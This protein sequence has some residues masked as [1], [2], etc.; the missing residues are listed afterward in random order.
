MKQRLSS[1]KKLKNFFSFGWLLRNDK[2]MMV[3]SLIIA[4]TIWFNVISGPANITD[5]SID[6][7]VSVDLSGSY[8]YQSGLRIVGDSTF[9]VKVNVSGPWATLVKLNESDFRVRADMTAITHDGVNDVPLNVSRNSTVTDYDVLSVTP[10][11]VQIACEYWE[12][13]AFFEVEVDTDGIM[14]EDP[15]TDVV[16]HAVIDTADF[17][18]GTV[19]LDGPEKVIE[20][21]ERLVAVIETTQ[22]MKKQTQ[23][24]VPL[25]AYDKNGREV[26]ISACEIR[27]IP[28]GKV[29]V[30]V[31]LWERR[32]MDVVY[33][34][35]NLP[36]NVTD[37]EAFIEKY[38]AV[39]PKTVEACGTEKALDSAQRHLNL[40]AID[41]DALLAAESMQLEYTVDVP[42]EKGT[43]EPVTVTVKLAVD[44]LQSLTVTVTPDDEHVR[45]VNA[46]GED[47]SDEILDAYMVNVPN[48]QKSLNLSL[49]GAAE[50]IAT[51]TSDDFV[52]TVTLDETTD[53]AV[54]SY[55]ATVTVDGYEDVWIFGE[56]RLGEYRMTVELSQGRAVLQNE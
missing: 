20:S 21:I 8:A 4:A 25:T 41:F 16:G 18:N 52:W 29:R 10:S 35:E 3:V 31:P 19:T 56:S 38:I 17:Q 37:H 28:S 40:G 6:V 15:E 53:P 30:T 42:T 22:P 24:E 49:V 7:E 11:T 48:G 23:F 27:E 47:I 50:S 2:L 51:I 14:V 13:G 54:D 9:N 46:N 26:D 33:T 55:V 45:F 12:Q 44:A 5:R 1:M 39:E 34:V 32:T 36:S 43:E